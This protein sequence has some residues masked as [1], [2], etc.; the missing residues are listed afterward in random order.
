MTSTSLLTLPGQFSPLPRILVADDFDLG[1]NGWMD[2]R[3]NFVDEG[4][5]AHSRELDF[6]SW[7]SVML[8]SATFPFSG[9]HGSA[10]GTYSLRLATR[11]EAA[12]A[13]ERPASGSMSLAIKRLSRPP[14]ATRLK[15][16]ALIA[17]TTEQDRPG[18]GVDAMRAF[19][20]FVDLQDGEHRYMPGVRYVNAVD[21][22][23]VRR[24]QYYTATAASASEWNYGQPG[25]HQPGVDPQWFGERHADGSTAATA[26]F[27][28]RPQQLIYNETDD[29][30]NWMPL[31]MEVDLVARTYTS[32]SAGDQEY[33]FP[34]ESRPT[35]APTYDNIGGLVNPVFFVETDGDR[36][37]SL[38]LDSVVVSYATTDDDRAEE[39]R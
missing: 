22:A 33:S 24:W 19:G 13:T 25:W 28:G 32:F 30:I 21:G 27:E 23:R 8:S 20:L 31:A 39:S 4:F 5:A 14:R 11:S 15:V 7:G 29:K 1:M 6:E 36:R 3:P 9:T 16:E 26:W 12:G 35:L 37:V 38:Y 10:S 34:P 2:L 17:Y 18:L